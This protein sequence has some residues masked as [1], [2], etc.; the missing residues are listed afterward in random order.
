MPTVEYVGPLDKTI[1]ENESE[2]NIEYV[3]PLESQD[4]PRETE[5]KSAPPPTTWDKITSVFNVF[6]DPEKEAAKAVISLVD[7]E[8]LGISPSAAYRYRDAI[9]RGVKINPIAASKVS[10]A[11]ER[12]TQSWETGKKENAASEIAYQYITTGDPKY[13][14]AAQ[15]VGLPTEEDI[16]I[17]E[18]RIEDAVR[19]AAKLTPMMLD[20]A[21]EGG[22][23]GAAIG[24][25]FGLITVLAGHPELAPA[26]MEAGFKIGGIQGAFESSLRKEAGSALLEII[27]FKDAEGRQIDP[28]IARAAAYGIGVLN[29]GIEVAQIS[30]LL[31]TIPGADRLFTEAI[32]DTVTSKTVKQQLLSLAGAYADTVAT[33]TGQEVAQESVNIIFGEL[34]KRVNNNLKGTDISPISVDEIISR[35][36]E[37]AI[38]SAKGFSVIAAPGIALRA[39]G[40][41]VQ[42]KPRTEVT[43]KTPLPPEAESVKSTVEKQGGFVLGEHNGQ[44]IIAKPETGDITT[45]P[46]EATPEEVIKQLAYEEETVPDIPEVQLDTAFNE[47]VV[48]DKEV[49]AEDMIKSI[50]AK[51]KAQDNLYEKENPSWDRSPEINKIRLQ[52]SVN[53]KSYADIKSIPYDEKVTVYRATIPGGE[54]EPG[55][56]VTPDKEVAKFYAKDMVGQR[57]EQEAQIIKK[58][59]KASEI[60]LHPS[61]QAIGVENEF[62]YHPIR[63]EV[64]AHIQEIQQPKGIE[65]PVIAPKMSKEELLNMDFKR[66]SGSYSPKSAFDIRESINT[67]G[68]AEHETVTD[69]AKHEDQWRFNEI[70]DKDPNNPSEYKTPQSIINAIRKG[71]EITVYRTSDIG[72]ILPGAYVTELKKYA[73]DHGERSINAPHELYSLK[74]YPDELVT[75]GDPHEFIYI[76]RNI[77]IAYDRYLKQTKNNILSNESGAIDIAKFIELG[78][79]IWDEGHTNY[80]AFRAQLQTV[81]GDTWEKV[82]DIALKIYN[83]VREF[84]RQLGERG[85]IGKSDKEAKKHIREMTGQVKGKPTVTEPA[86]LK[87]SM[88]KAEIASKAGFKEGVQAGIDKALTPKE[89][90]LKQRIR[91]ITGQTGDKATI[92]EDKALKAAFSKAVKAAR[93][94]YRAGNKEGMA[95]EKEKIKDILTWKKYAEFRKK[96]IQKD[97][98]TLKKIKEK[99]VGKIALD[100]QEKI[101]ELLAD[102]DL[103]TPTEETI[104]KLKDL[105]DF[106]EREGVPLGISQAELNQL[107]RLSKTPFKDMSISAQKDLLDMAKKLY[108]LGELKQNLK[109][110]KEAREQQRQLD[111]LIESTV[112]LDPVLSGEKKP[113]KADNLKVGFHKV[114][115]DVL[116]TFRQADI[117]DG[118]KE[119]QGENVRLIKEEMHAEISAKNEAQR[120]MHEGIISKIQKLG[121]DE[122]TEEM[123]RRINVV[124]MAE[125]GARSQTASLM[126]KYGMASFP[127]L[128]DTE[129]AIVNIIR[130]EVG[131]KTENVAK[132]YEGRENLTF[133]KVD[134]YFPIK[135]EKEFNLSPADTINQDRYRTKQVEQG[136]TIK[137]LPGVDKVIREDF[138][139][140]AEDAIIDQEWYI[141]L[142]PL[143]DRHNALIRTPEYKAAA[144]DMMWNWWKDQVDIVARKGWSAT[145]RGNPALRTMR[146]NL[147]QAVLGF[148]A[149]SIIM[150][151]FAVFDAVSYV[152]ANWGPVAGAEVG[153]EVTKAWINPIK[154]MEFVKESP[155]L[156]LRKAGELAIEETLEQAR[157]MKGIKKTIIK[158]SLKGIQIADIIT[159]AGVEKGI[160]KILKKHN[161][162]NAETEADFLMNVVSGSSEVTIRPHILARG[163]GAR[164]WFTFQTFFLNRWGMISHDLIRTGL[165]G[166]T[167]R[168][169]LSLLGL[170]ILMAGGMAEDK[171]RDLIYEMT[172]GKNSNISDEAFYKKVLLYLPR[173]IP[174]LGNLFEKWGSAE[175]PVMRQA[176]KIGTGTQQL[177]EGKWSKGLSK[178]LEGIMTLLLGIPGTTQ[179]FDLMEG[180]TQDEKKSERR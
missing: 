128:N 26:M 164:T 166:T 148:K 121:I 132:V 84:N 55:D 6:D 112:N 63:E 16:F 139:S 2:N 158:S 40:L 70:F 71:K 73:I 82:K 68:T 44:V 99:A 169:A 95:K 62:I 25:G 39:G 146:L 49:S 74:V 156:K 9:D 150:Q 11:R 33:E 18:S 137:R 120:R 58:S 37:T 106:I 23:K 105:Q 56:F 54:I 98:K 113:T 179:L 143:L 136:F 170:T 57:G 176:E 79:S 81:V 130:T 122:I 111:T 88:K 69:L 4:V 35:L 61:H 8:T 114:S 31:K 94:A 20:T 157:G 160:L 110:N 149:T 171:A 13:L 144:G 34:A 116:H 50:E 127:E 85:D 154:A 104:D 107:D 87:A 89:E 177:V 53:T 36:K 21:L 27:N 124:L 131:S 3:G 125:Q 118:V 93:E 102:I 46:I 138:L 5:I 173:Q 92:G 101:G 155:A 91:R 59:V 100:Y 12:I 159:A 43:V 108:N 172:T 167:K 175:P 109:E 141:Q 7:A 145:A 48:S 76:P 129:R 168:K 51:S 19:S 165:K 28:D 60:K 134:K 151:P 42:T 153:A 75:L 29:A 178:V 32:I 90:S 97:I 119:Y 163:E 45:I 77:D 41:A 1:P 174:I 72:D 14:E 83:M 115:M 142:Q 147:N 180:A 103:T 86:A 140:V 64:K 123:T 117:A 135:Y 52:K 17:P 152:T 161:I 80:Q 10:T 22:W 162:S 65:Y 30:T 24:T 15:K 133:P 66:T 67:Q 38:E 78:K 96:E 126:A 47:M